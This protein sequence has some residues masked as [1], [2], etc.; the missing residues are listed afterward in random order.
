VDGIGL[1]DGWIGGLLERMTLLLA[2]CVS[3][4]LRTETLREIKESMGQSE[5]KERDFKE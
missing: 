3:V 1:E 2:V 5:A 4:S